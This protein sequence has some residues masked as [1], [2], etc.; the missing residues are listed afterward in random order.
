MPPS[1]TTTS[2]PCDSSTAWNARSHGWFLISALTLPRKS[3][4]RTMVRPLN[5]ANPATTS[6]RS[7]LS[8]VTVMRAACDCAL[9]RACVA[10]Y[11]S[12]ETVAPLAAGVTTL[13]ASVPALRAAAGGVVEPAG[14]PPGVPPHRDAEP[15]ALQVDPEPGRIGQREVLDVD[16]ASEPAH[17]PHAAGRREHADGPD[18]PVP[19]PPPA[20]PAPPA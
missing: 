15:R 12:I 16:R 10:R 6:R 17:D 7:A 8:H 18:L 11:S 9:S 4:E 5:A 1:R 14:V 2:R 19:R 20:P 3:F 13:A